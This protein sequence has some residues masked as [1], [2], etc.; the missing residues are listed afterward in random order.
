MKGMK[1][2]KDMKKY[3][4]LLLTLILVLSIAP[5]PAYAEGG[6]EEQDQPLTEETLEE[7]TSSPICSVKTLRTSTCA[8]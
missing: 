7:E 1:H 2:M 3:L 8:R 6:L 5:L 4:S